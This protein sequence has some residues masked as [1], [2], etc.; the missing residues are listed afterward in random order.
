MKEWININGSTKICGQCAHKAYLGVNA[1]GQHVYGFK[2]EGRCKE[3]RADESKELELSDFVTE[4][5][6]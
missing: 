6:I 3:N 1:Q 2:R 5:Q 4:S